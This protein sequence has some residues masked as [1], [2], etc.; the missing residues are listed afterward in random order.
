MFLAADFNPWY[1]AFGRSSAAT[2]CRIRVDHAAYPTGTSIKSDNLML[3]YGAAD[4]RIAVA[5]TKIQTL[6][7]ALKEE[8]K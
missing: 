4:T 1:N 2:H 5:T 7:D 8:G 6:L 3:Y